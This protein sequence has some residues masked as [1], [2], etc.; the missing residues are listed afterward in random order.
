[1]NRKINLILLAGILSLGMN[2]WAQNSPMEINKNYVP[3]L[4]QHN[5]LLLSNN[6]TAIYWNANDSL[7]QFSLAYHKENGNYKPTMIGASKNSFILSTDSYKKVAKTMLWGA[8]EYNK[9]IEQDMCYTNVYDSYR[10][11]PYLYADT[12]GGDAY[13]REQFSFN[14]KLSTPLNDRLFLGT[15]VEY[16][17][18]LGAQSRDPRAENKIMNLNS[19]LGLFYLFGENIKLGVNGVYAYFNE[20]IDINVVEQNTTHTIFNLTGLGTY[21]NHESSTFYRL[22]KRHTVGGDVQLST[23]NNIVEVGYRSFDEIVLDGRKESGATW[24]TIKDDSRLR[25]CNYA[26]NDIYT[27]HKGS[28]T[29]QLKLSANMQKIV[30]TEI[31]QELQKVNEDYDIYQWTTFNEEDKYTNTTQSA[32]FSY[33]YAK[34]STPFLRNYSIEMEANIED[35]EERYYFPNQ[36]ISYTNID[37]SLSVSK[38]FSWQKHRIDTK[39]CMGA[40]N[41]LSQQINLTQ[42]SVF[43]ELITVPEYNYFSSDHINGYIDINYDYSINDTK[44]IFINARYQH[45]HSDEFNR[46]SMNITTGYLF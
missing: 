1:M 9:S 41:N 27:L 6:P 30:G 28:G 20:D 26:L 36:K 23:G 44:R 33:E 5:P 40:K 25:G 16:M 11:T 39:L 14:T 15:Q 19:K 7:G 43:T 12:I 24:S 46:S 22:Y 35:H 8:F 37:Y 10:N 31:L 29:H 4:T 18:G 45:V 32:S 21:S 42:T 38:L 17:V 13:D 2:A 3:I 34:Y